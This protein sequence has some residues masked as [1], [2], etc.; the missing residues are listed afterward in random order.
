M[1]EIVLKYYRKLLRNGFDYAGKIENPSIYLDSIGENLPI[2]GRLGRD[3]I[4][5]YIRVE[6]DR[7]AEIKYLCTCDPTANV[8]FEVLCA[9]IQGKTLKEAQALNPDAFTE[10][11][12]VADPDLL[13]KAKGSIELLNRGIKRYL[14]EGQPETEKV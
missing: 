9:S 13:K 14:A 1:N 12:G 3:Y 7:I 8:V 6:D 4:H 10:V 11:L 2:C 5:L